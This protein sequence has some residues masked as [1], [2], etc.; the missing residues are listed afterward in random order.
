MNLH[1]FLRSRYS[2]AIGKG[3]V[4]LVNEKL[5]KLIYSV[6]QL[7]QKELDRLAVISM[8]GLAAEG[9]EYNKVVGQSSDLST[10]QVMCFRGIG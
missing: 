5:Q 7:D 10:L 1:L 6:Y 9:L 8:V 3:H 4:N 2:L